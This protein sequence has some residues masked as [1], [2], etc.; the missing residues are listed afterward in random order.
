M[1]ISGWNLSLS[2]FFRIVD[3]FLMQ[4]SIIS[5]AFIAGDRCY[6]TWKPFKHRQM[7]TRKYYIGILLIWS[8][9][10]VISSVLL[11]THYILFYDLSFYIWSSLFSAVTLI[12]CGCYLAI[13]IKFKMQ[14]VQMNIMHQNRISQEKRLT[15]ILMVICFITVLSWLLLIITNS[16]PYQALDT[17]TRFSFDL[18]NYSNCFINPIFYAL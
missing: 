12:I 6:A 16:L 9:A 17:N 1:W 2:Q 10:L 8:L 7:T 18:L 3:N 5:A 14:V 15:K 11:T 4:A 13:W